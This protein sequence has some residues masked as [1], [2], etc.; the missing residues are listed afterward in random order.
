MA[1]GESLASI[2]ANDQEKLD[3][4]KERFLKAYHITKENAKRQPLIRGTVPE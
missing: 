4:A 3:M 2:Y 1:Q